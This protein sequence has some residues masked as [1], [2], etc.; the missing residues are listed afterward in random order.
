VRLRELKERAIVLLVVAPGTS[1]CEEGGLID[2][3]L[4]VVVEW[5]LNIALK[6]FQRENEVVAFPR[7]FR[8]DGELCA[9]PGSVVVLFAEENHVRGCGLSDQPR[10]I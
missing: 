7:Q 4:K 10:E 9:V 8:Q 5:P 6:H 2:A 3:I 1:V